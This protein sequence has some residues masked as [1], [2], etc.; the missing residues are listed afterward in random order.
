MLCD[1]LF[2]D[3]GAIAVWGWDAEEQ[4]FFRLRRGDQ[5]ERGKGYWVYVVAGR[6][7]SRGLPE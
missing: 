3:C 7:G 2:D 1:E 4:S 5:L 6:T